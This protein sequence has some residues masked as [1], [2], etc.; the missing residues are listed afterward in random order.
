M[1]DVPFNGDG[2]FTW[3]RFDAVYV[4][5]LANAWG[6]LASRTIAMVERYCSGVVPAGARQLANYSIYRLCMGEVG[7][8]GFLPHEALKIV[9]DH[10]ARSNEFV[11]QSAPW[12]LAKDPE[13]RGALE[14]TLATLILALAWQAVHLSPFMPERTEELWR[15]LG[16]PGSV[17]HQRFASLDTLNPT[18]WRVEK[19]NPLFPRPT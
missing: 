16:A 10:V 19:G 15:Q 12:K 5:D 2:E 18:G 17:H 4:A 14:E 11:D 8:R 6:N 9:R 13:Q 3:E 7:G 1:R